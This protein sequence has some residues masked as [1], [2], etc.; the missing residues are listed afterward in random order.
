MVSHRDDT[1]QKSFPGG[2]SRKK[3]VKKDPDVPTVGID[4]GTPFLG[5]DASLL[6]PIL[7]LAGTI[8][9]T[10]TQDQLDRIRQVLIPVHRNSWISGGSLRRL[11]VATGVILLWKGFINR[12]VQ[13]LTG[14]LEKVPEVREWRKAQCK[15]EQEERPQKLIKS[16]QQ[17]EQLQQEA[18]ED[19]NQFEQEQKQKDIQNKGTTEWKDDFKDGNDPRKIVVPDNYRRLPFP[20]QLEYTRQIGSLLCYHNLRYA[21]VSPAGVGPENLPPDQ[22][23]HITDQG[24]FKHDYNAISRLALNKGKSKLDSMPETL[25]EEYNTALGKTNQV[26]DILDQQA[27]KLEVQRKLDPPLERQSPEAVRKSIELQ[28]TRDA[29]NDAKN[30]RSRFSMQNAFTQ[31]PSGGTRSVV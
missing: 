14:A 9:G 22:G 30:A 10:F 24:V 25:H 1:L 5:P 23:F 4:P 21:D 29:L 16:F 17:Q 12:E 13:A 8:P 27:Q 6:N 15:A 3:K 18:L 19:R 2:E 11:L 26:Q 28:N 7:K 31:E 20:D